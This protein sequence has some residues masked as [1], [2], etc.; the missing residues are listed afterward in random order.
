MAKGGMKKDDH[1][2]HM[3]QGGNSKLGAMLQNAERKPMVKATDAELGL[4]T[5]LRIIPDTWNNISW[6]VQNSVAELVKTCIENRR[7]SEMVW[8]YAVAANV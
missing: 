2:D 1:Q 6:V 3:P 7:H 5:M 8:M 4:E